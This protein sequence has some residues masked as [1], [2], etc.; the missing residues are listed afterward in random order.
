MTVYMKKRFGMAAAKR[1]AVYTATMIVWTA[2]GI[3]HGASWRYVAWGV[4]NGAVILLSEELSPLYRRFHKRFPKL[5]GTVGYRAFQVLRTFLLLCCLRIF[6]RYASLKIAIRSFLHMFK[7]FDLHALSKK[8]FL[9]MGMT[10]VDYAICFAGVLVMF[11]V[12]MLGR[13]Q[14][15]RGWISERSY[16]VKYILFLLLF[17]ATVLFGVYGVG[18]DASSFIYNQF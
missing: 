12:S 8:E 17:L 7:K 9:D 14:S 18:Y 5:T 6:D 16:S 3:W 2:T 13:R 15:V 11:F 1:T 4:C 10:G